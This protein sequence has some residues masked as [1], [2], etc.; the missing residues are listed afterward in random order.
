MASSAAPTLENCIGSCYGDFSDIS[1][2]CAICAFAAECRQYCLERGLLKDEDFSKL[3][4]KQK[5]TKKRKEV[6]N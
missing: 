4:P 1:D 6:E 2:E 3:V 5:K